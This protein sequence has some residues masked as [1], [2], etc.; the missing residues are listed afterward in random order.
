MGVSSWSFTTSCSHLKRMLDAF[1]THRED[2]GG[3]E[4]Y[5]NSVSH[6]THVAKSAVYVTL[7]IVSDCLIVYR[8][9]V[10]L[11]NKIMLGLLSLLVLAT[12][13]LAYR[14]IYTLAHMPRDGSVYA[15][16]LSAWIT[17]F[18]VLSAATNVLASALIA[19]RIWSINRRLGS[20]SH[21]G[22]TG[23]HP[24]IVIVVESGAVY[25]ASLIILTVLYTTGD[26]AQYIVL[27]AITPL[28]GIVFSLIIIRVGLKLAGGDANHGSA[29]WKLSVSEGSGGGRRSQPA[30]HTMA[31]PIAVQM[32]TVYHTDARDISDEHSFSQGT[33][34]KDLEAASPDWPTTGKPEA[35]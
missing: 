4:F 5:F 16:D 12:A 34:D 25:A 6:V 8:A 26:H 28:I 27:D 20:F 18:N 2:E 32:N 10:V 3:P 21:T 22:K 31:R 14:N 17:S 23:I 33:A 1:Y 11:R 24:V 15:S 7:T 30:R 9:W 19:H 13:V 29:T 35:V